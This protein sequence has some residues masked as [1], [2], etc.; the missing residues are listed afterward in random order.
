MRAM[1]MFHELTGSVSENSIF[2]QLGES[3]K[4]SKSFCATSTHLHVVLAVGLTCLTTTTK[5]AKRRDSHLNF[6]QRLAQL[7]SQLRH[8]CAK[9]YAILPTYLVRKLCHTLAMTYIMASY[10]SMS[11]SVADIEYNATAATFYLGRC[12]LINAL[13]LC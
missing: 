3:G 6:S 7:Q 4:L 13:S 11:E 8:A 10:N 9:G 12:G 1:S 5:H 2:G